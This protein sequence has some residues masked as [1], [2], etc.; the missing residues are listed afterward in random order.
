MPVIVKV[1]SL[2][3][4]SMLA[5]P[6]AV[7]AQTGPTGQAGQSTARAPVATGQST[8]TKRDSDGSLHTTVKG[9]ASSG[10]TTATTR[11]GGADDA[12][13]NEERTNSPAATSGAVDGR[14]ALAPGGAMTGPSGAPAVGGGHG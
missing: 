10:G 11:Q 6:L 8:T 5:L 9:S 12:R 4:L 2:A 7:H 1:S 3:A 13:A 14:N